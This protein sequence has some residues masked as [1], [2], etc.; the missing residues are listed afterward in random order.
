MLGRVHFLINDEWELND[1]SNVNFNYSFQPKNVKAP[2]EFRVK[3]LAS[4][5]FYQAI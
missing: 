5:N 2:T 4:K 1:S 3:F